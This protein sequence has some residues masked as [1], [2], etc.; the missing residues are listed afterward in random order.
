[1]GKSK[2]FRYPRQGKLAGALTRY[3]IG[4]A[5]LAEAIQLSPSTISCIIS[6]RIDYKSSVGRKILTYLRLKT[7]DKLT[8][9]D[10]MQ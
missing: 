9:D 4:Y 5:E 1:M 6:G 8:L 2:E 3:D 7:E 10:I